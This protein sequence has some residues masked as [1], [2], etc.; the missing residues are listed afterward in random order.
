MLATTDASI[1]CSQ[2]VFAS[3]MIVFFLLMIGWIIFIYKIFDRK[4]EDNH[5]KRIRR[6]EERQQENENRTL[7]SI[8]FLLEEIKYILEKK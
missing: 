5:Q 2:A 8:K 4:D 7:D 1:E 6:E 3:V